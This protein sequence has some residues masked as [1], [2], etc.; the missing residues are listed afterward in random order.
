MNAKKHF[1]RERPSIDNEKSL[2]QAQKASFSNQH[3]LIASSQAEASKR[4]L[5]A[6]RKIIDIEKKKF[7]LNVQVESS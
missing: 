1:K 4:T 7:K 5:Q 6:S 2:K 3:F